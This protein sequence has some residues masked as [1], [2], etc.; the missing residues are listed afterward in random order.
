MESYLQSIQ[1]KGNKREKKGEYTTAPI[2][3]SFGLK[4]HM[5]KIKTISIYTC[6]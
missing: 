6:A 5:Q 4:L 1:F 2:A 3:C